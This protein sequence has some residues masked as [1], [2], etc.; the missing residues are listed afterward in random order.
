MSQAFYL[1]GT[2]SLHERATIAAHGVMSRDTIL[3]LLNAALSTKMTQL[4]RCKQHYYSAGQDEVA[5]REEL[6]E[7]AVEDS[8]HTDRLV[9]RI[10]QLGGLPDFGAQ[11]LSEDAPS[12]HGATS[13]DLR[14]VLAD[15]LAAR[16]CAIESYRE[17]VELIA[18]YDETT[19]G[20]LE[21]LMRRDQRYF[22]SLSRHLTV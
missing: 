9:E 19:A 20:L 2:T 12:D 5:L 17:L 7:Q 10:L 22:D 11:S 3:K 15:Y 13:V 8:L 4:V 21:D 1:E 6:F 16:H 14:G 18:S